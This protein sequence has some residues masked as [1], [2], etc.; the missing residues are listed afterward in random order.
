MSSEPNSLHEEARQVQ[1]KFLFYS[2][3]LTFTILGLAIQTASFGANV[4][5]DSAELLA[6]LILLI[7]GFNGL[8]LLKEIPHL[9]NLVVKKERAPSDEKVKGRLAQRVSRT[10]TNYERH[11]SA[12]RWGVGLLVASRGLVPA[13]DLFGQLWGLR[14]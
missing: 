7:S 12:F 8:S 10:N 11:L 14:L 2:V 6:W 1:S 4:V 3:A 9:F 13:L 5:A